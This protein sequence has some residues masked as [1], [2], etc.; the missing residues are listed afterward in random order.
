MT[1]PRLRQHDP[2]LSGL[3]LILMMAIAASKA[4]SKPKPSRAG[5]QTARQLFET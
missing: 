1:S 2:K 5:M 4:N 3:Q